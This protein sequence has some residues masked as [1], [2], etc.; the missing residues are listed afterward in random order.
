MKKRPLLLYIFIYKMIHHFVL[1]AA[2]VVSRP[3]PVSLSPAQ[4]GV[5]HRMCIHMQAAENRGQEEE[6]QAVVLRM[7]QLQSRLNAAVN[8][9]RFEEATDLANRLRLLELEHAEVALLTTSTT[10][11][12]Q[13][14]STQEAWAWAKLTEESTKVG[15]MSG[16]V[17]GQAGPGP[18]PGRDTG[19]RC[20]P[21]PEQM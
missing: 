16:G 20:E 13:S 7:R 11:H 9:E 5:R 21:W 19:P 10:Q 14:R 18:S 17:V 8:A 1:A 12:L 2:T 15:P 3:H 6:R 4:F